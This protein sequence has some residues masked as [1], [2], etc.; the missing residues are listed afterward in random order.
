MKCLVCIHYIPGMQQTP[1][2]SISCCYCCFYSMPRRGAW[3]VYIQVAVFHLRDVLKPC[4]P[5]SNPPDSLPAHSSVPSPI[6][7]LHEMCCHCPKP[8]LF[9]DSTVQLFTCPLN[10]SFL[11]AYC[12]PKCLEHSGNRTQFLTLKQTIDYFFSC[13]VSLTSIIISVVYM[14]VPFFPP[15][16]RKFFN[17]KNLVL[18]FLSPL[19]CFA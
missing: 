19:K 3:L 13:T 2:R 4:S 8:C 17:G 18:L 7:Y 15:Q 9:N 10:K 12:E 5:H 6:P 16:Y 14:K 11:R 1:R